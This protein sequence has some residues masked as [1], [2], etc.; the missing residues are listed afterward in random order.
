MLRWMMVGLVSVAALAATAREVRRPLPPRRVPHGVRTNAVQKAAQPARQRLLQTSGAGPASVDVLV[1]YDAFARRWVE[2]DGGDVTNFAGSAVARMNVA[3]TNSG[4]Q[5]SLLFRLA[6]VESVGAVGGTDFDGTLDAVTSGT[7]E[8]KVVR[9]ARERLGAD[10]AVTLIDTGSA[11]GTTGL[12]WALDSEGYDDFSEYAFSICAIRAVAE[13]HTMTHEVGHLMGAGHSDRQAP[14]LDPGP[15]LHPYSSGCYFET[16]GVPC[17]T[18][19]A[20]D[21]DGYG[22]LYEETPYFSTPEVALAGVPVGTPTN[23]NARTLRETAVYVSGFR[24]AETECQH[25]ATI[26]IWT[27]GSGEV[28]DKGDDGDVWQW[29]RGCRRWV[30]TPVGFDRTR[31]T[32]VICHGHANSIDETWVREMAESMPQ[33]A[34]VLAVN[35]GDAADQLLP[36]DSAWYIPD[37]VERME[38]SLS[39]VYGIRPEMTTFIGHSHGAHV[40][41]NAV[42]DLGQD[43]PVAR[44]VGLDT[45]TDEFGVHAWNFKVVSWVPYETVSYGPD[46]WM[47]AIRFRCRQVEFYKTSWILSLSREMAYGH[48][49]FVVVGADGLPE[50]LLD[51][52]HSEESLEDEGEIARHS[53]SHDWFTRTIRDPVRYAGLGFNFAGDSALAGASGFCGLIRE[54]VLRAPMGC[55]VTFSG[56]EE[57]MAKMSPRYYDWGQVFNLPT[58]SIRA[59]DDETFAGWAGSNGRR[60]DDGV[61][62]FNLGRGGETVTMTAIWK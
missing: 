33:E 28:C 5:A 51:I 34:N 45:S 8:W 39:S 61:L 24:H 12:S 19:M 9:E 25:E 26:E 50:K 7:G 14:W 47:D 32:Y 43:V 38:W 41:A 17:R 27:P 31:Q 54:T 16:N 21:D 44:F 6:G 62:V 15:L 56:G 53:F 20:Y 1:A 46:R 4:I 2:K 11:Y 57:G 49:N 36:H 55:F 3:V 13:S 60:Y 40:A 48:F 37:V 18:I 59:D 42:F 29:C 35:W 30:L 58:P 23:D 10:V 22:N 52:A